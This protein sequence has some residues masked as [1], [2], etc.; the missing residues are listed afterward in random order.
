MK[1]L[2]GVNSIEQIF[3]HKN[4]KIMISIISYL[5][6]NELINLRNTNK[7][8]YSILKEKKIIKEY[9]KLGCITS[10]TRQIIIIIQY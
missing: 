2:K 4:I 5:E 1:S 10:K 6:F 9:C 8:F 7:N 3:Q